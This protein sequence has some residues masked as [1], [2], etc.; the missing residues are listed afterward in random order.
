MQTAIHTPPYLQQSQQPQAHHHLPQDQFDEAAFEAAFDA[1]MQDA[2]TD[3]DT[4]M[5][6]QHAHSDVLD[7]FDF[8]SFLTKE[9]AQESFKVD[10]YP[11]RMYTIR[12]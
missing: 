8:D 7:N 4:A 11:H 3:K 10:V 2:S 6:D 12:R 1:A 9:P 5:Q